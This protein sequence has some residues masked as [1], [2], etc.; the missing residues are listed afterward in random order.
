MVVVERTLGAVLVGGASSR[1]G[2]DKALV[3]FDGR[4]LL[5]HQLGT[6][7]D[8]GIARR[9]Y[10][11]GEFREDVAES[12]HVADLYPAQGPLG[13]LISALSAASDLRFGTP[14]V[15]VVVIVAVDLP[16]VTPA[17]IACL[18]K[19][20]GLV[21][22]HALLPLAR[23]RRCLTQASVRCIALWRP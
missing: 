14:A 18:R 3:K 21:S 17:T 22:P 1:F 2:S 8:A 7:R 6:L 13:A 10:V 19:N 23:C 12:E 20:T 16:L 11:G 4:S 15:E 5:H 9:V